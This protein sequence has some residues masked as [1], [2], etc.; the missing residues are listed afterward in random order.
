MPLTDPAR[1]FSNRDL[2]AGTPLQALSAVVQS[3]GVNPMRKSRLDLSL[4]RTIAISLFPYYSKIFDRL[5]WRVRWIKT[6][7]E[8]VDS[9]M[10][11]S[12]EEMYK[13]L[14][15]NFFSDPI[16]LFEFGVY[17]GD[18]LREWCAL[19]THPQTRFFGFDSFEGLPEDWT[20]EWPKG[21]FNTSK[22]LPD[23]GDTRIQFVSGWFQR[24][25]PG[26]LMSYKPK[27]RLVIHNDSDL[28]SSTLFCLTAMDR[29]I[30][31]GTIVIF[32]EFSDALHEYRALTDYAIAY[33]RKFSIIAATERFVQAAIQVT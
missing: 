30:V 11:H 13:H 24:T 15:Q 10:F 3:L 20:S 27:N 9:P 16:D 26:F 21:S 1:H 6:V 29:L 28:Y 25:L 33:M 12:R 8:C 19:N 4:K 31:P 7:R 17:K 23:I 22:Q 14:N 18:S 2:S 32:D 5:N